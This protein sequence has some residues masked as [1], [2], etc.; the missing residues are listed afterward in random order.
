LRT[1]CGDIGDGLIF[2]F[3]LQIYWSPGIEDLGSGIEGYSVQGTGI[4]GSDPFLPSRT[5]QSSRSPSTSQ[6]Q[7]SHEN[8]RHHSRQAPH[9][10]YRHRG[11]HSIKASSITDGITDTNAIMDITDIRVIC[12]RRGENMPAIAKLH[13]NYVMHQNSIRYGSYTLDPTFE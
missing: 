13:L 11:H 5:S 4:F 6:N 12:K 9:R 7:G 3:R 8:H 2:W 10:R 1:T